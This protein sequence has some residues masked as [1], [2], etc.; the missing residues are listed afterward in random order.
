MTMRF[1]DTPTAVDNG[2]DDHGDCFHLVQPPKLKI[3]AHNAYQDDVNIH[4][5]FF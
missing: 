5:T 2:D 1:T 3:A 4:P